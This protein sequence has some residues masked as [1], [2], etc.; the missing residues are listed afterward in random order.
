MSDK[1]VF[2]RIEMELWALLYARDYAVGR[3]NR[4]KRD[5]SLCFESVTS[6][7][8][9]GLPADSSL[10]FRVMKANVEHKGSS[11]NLSMLLQICSDDF[12]MINDRLRSLTT[13]PDK[14][15]APAKF[16]ANK[17]K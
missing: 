16:K 11:I 2:D 3:S 6:W 8:L 15:K 7:I 10:R 9:E 1:Q 5:E 12:K 13:K 4:T 17:S 14:P